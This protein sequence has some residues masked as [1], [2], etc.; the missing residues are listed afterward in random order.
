[1]NQFYQLTA[2]LIK[3]MFREDTPAI[4]DGKFPVGSEPYIVLTRMRELVD[5]KK[6]NTA[7][8]MLFDVFDKKKPYYIRVGLE[9]YNR[10]AAFSDEELEAADFSAEEIGEGIVDMM[11]FY[12]VKL[13]VRK[14][15]DVQN[16][17]NQ[18]APNVVADTADKK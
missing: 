12:G 6:I 9:F 4:P 17:E 13:A 18:S 14:K 3:T 15:P 1:M 16:P 8:N 5:E 2:F 11:N 7:E 10:I